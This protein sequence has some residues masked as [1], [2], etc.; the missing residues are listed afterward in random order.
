MTGSEILSLSV[1]VL[2]SLLCTGNCFHLR[3]GRDQGFIN[4][5]K[6]RCFSN[7]GQLSNAYFSLDG[8]DLESRVATFRADRALTFNIRPDLEGEYTC[9]DSSTGQLSDPISLICE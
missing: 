6:L 9:S 4:Q 3:H 7:Q 8:D 1:A 5:V 2:L